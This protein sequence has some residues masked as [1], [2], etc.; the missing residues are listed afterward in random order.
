MSLKPLNPCPV[1][2][3]IGYLIEKRDGVTLDNPEG[4]RWVRVPCY[5]CKGA[6]FLR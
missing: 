2:K 3:T 1:C 4:L 5:K 6:G